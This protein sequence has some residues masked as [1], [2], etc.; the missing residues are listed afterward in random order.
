MIDVIMQLYF[1]YFSHD[2]TM[3]ISLSLVALSFMMLSLFITND[4]VKSLP[5]KAKIIGIIVT[6][7]ILLTNSIVTVDNYIHAI[8][9]N[10][11]TQWIFNNNSTV[12]G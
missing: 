1:S 2:H 9:D 3:I 11:S 12:G 6:V 10:V 7:I 5:V 4:K 8:A